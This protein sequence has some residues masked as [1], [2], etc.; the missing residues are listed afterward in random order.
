MKLS[1]ELLHLVAG[2]FRVLAEPIRLQIVYRIAQDE[3]TVNEIV[4]CL[5][6]SQ[7]NVSQHLKV[8]TEAGILLRRQQK[9]CVYYKVSDPNIFPL[10]QIVWRSLKNISERQTKLLALIQKENTFFSPE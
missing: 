1:D 9:N 10:C 7:S 6:A 5:S 2:R 3:K 8:L 4:S